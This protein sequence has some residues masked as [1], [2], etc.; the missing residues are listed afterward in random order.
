[1]TEKELA[2]SVSPLP[3]KKEQVLEVV[4]EAAEGYEFTL[5]FNDKAQFYTYTHPENLSLEQTAEHLGVA[6]TALIH[7]IVKRGKKE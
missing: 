3:K 4:P 7:E 6:L 2:Q 1:M 5:K